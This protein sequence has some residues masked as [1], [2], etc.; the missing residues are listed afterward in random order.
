[1]KI[2]LL[3]GREVLISLKLS[4]QRLFSAFIEFGPGNDQIWSDLSLI[5]SEFW[6]VF[7]LILAILGPEYKVEALH[8]VLNPILVLKSTLS[9]SLKRNI[10][11][12]E[13]EFYET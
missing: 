1:M 6:S 7:G 5:L 2:K 11:F 13:F 10:A 8:M 12:R 9:K 3:W 4:T